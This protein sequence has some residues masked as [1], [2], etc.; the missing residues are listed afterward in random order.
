MISALGMQAPDGTPH[1]GYRPDIEGLRGIAVL[2]VLLCHA[3]LPGV[4]GG[5]VGVDV[6]F[7]IS[8]F[9][10]SRIILI[11]VLAGQF[12]FARFYRRRIKRLLPAFSLVSLA[13]AGAGL[14]LSLPDHLIDIGQSLVAS[15]VFA[16]NVLFWHE[17]GYFASAAELKPLLHSWS[18]GV[19]EQFYLVYPM[20]LIAG[21]RLSRRFGGAAI[22]L[23]ML[24]ASLAVSIAWTTGNTQAAFFLLPARAWELMVGACLALAAQPDLGRLVRES[25]SVAGIAMI[26]VAAMFFTDATPFPGV[27]ATLPVGGAALLI[28]SGG[29]TV[30]GRAALR[31]PPILFLGRI[32][33]SLYLWHWPLLAFARYRAIDG[34]DMT[35]AMLL[36]ALAVGLAW[37]TWRF[38]EQPMRRED[39]LTGRQPFV[40]AAVSS[41]VLIAI[42]GGLIASK[43]LPQRY[44][45]VTADLIATAADKDRRRDCIGIPTRII[46]VASPCL[47][48]AARTAPTVALWGDSHAHALI[49]S[50]GRVEGKWGRAVAF[51][52]YADCPPVIGIEKVG[53]SGCGAYGRA[54]LERLLSDRSIRDVV[55]VARHAAYLKGGTADWGPAEARHVERLAPGRAGQS[56]AATYEHGLGREVALL[57]GAGKMVVLVLPIPEVAYDVPRVAALLHLAGRDI[58]GFSRPYAMYESRQAD[59]RTFMTGIAARTGARI[60]DP[61]HWLCDGRRCR[62][63][64]DGRLLYYDDDHLSVL[65]ATRLANDISAVVDG[66]ANGTRVSRR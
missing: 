60:V 38:V 34:I 11:D 44:D 21:L 63:S 24:L 55:I 64:E 40:F 57:R 18:L 37:L 13:V 14:A 22:T 35:T 41:I 58:D 30:A 52:G 59:V 33:Y 49:S 45:G 10:I 47:Y 8:G 19:E 28:L 23:A 25:V 31:N 17:T 5:F 39:R 62:V 15:G 3:G 6:F 26:G 32:S 51:F 65:G 2:L 54:V 66:P 50:M 16:T 48:G 46:P 61:A 9:L 43:G 53:D 29:D 42:G 27:A 36:L 1:L 12:S 4:R 20:L 56:L 7:V